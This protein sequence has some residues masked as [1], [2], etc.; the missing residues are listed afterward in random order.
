M[1]KGTSNGLLFS[2][3]F[4]DKKSIAL[5]AGPLI[6]AGII[7]LYHPDITRPEIGYTLAIALWMAVWWIFEPVS[8]AITSLLPVVLFP[9]LG[10]MNGQTVSSA[11][12]NHVIFLF[13]GGFLMALAMQRWN[14]HRRIALNILSVTGTSKS[15][16]L[17]GFM[18]ATAF[19]SMW[20]SNTATAMMIVPIL[21]SVLVVIEPEPGKKRSFS[22]GLLLGIA[23]SASIGGIITLVGTPPNLSFIRIYQ[24]MFPQAPAI[25]F[26][27]WMLFAVPI[28]I[29]LLVF[30]YFLLIQ[31]YSKGFENNIAITE[32]PVR[33]MR[34]ELGP[35]S[36]EE[37]AVMICFVLMAFL[38][39]TR[40]DIGLGT[41][42]LK[43]WAS[44]FNKPEF[45]NDGTIAIAI[46]LPLFMIPVKG[47]PGTRILDWETAS[48]LPWN[49]VLLFGGG[50][51][52]AN[53]FRDS[54]LSLWLGEKL[55]GISVLPPIVII[56]IICLLVT[57]LTELTSNTATI[58]MILPV[59]AGMAIAT[60]TNPLL[61]MVPATISGSMAFMLPAATPPN[62]I[63]FGTNRI[64]I[65]EMARTGFW[66]N[67]IGAVVITLVF[68]YLGS[69][70]F[71]I[72]PGSFP[73][74]AVPP[75]K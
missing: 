17:M 58:E 15:R 20:M 75:V 23:Y 25:S 10:V 49:I 18:L 64:T 4:T 14:L 16:L 5:L 47:Q 35:M 39:I 43:G 70:I 19:L 62:A 29:L 61:F 54:G 22:T 37:K 44:L 60:H 71:N 2:S 51:A 12:F 32:L 52:L 42:T 45:I 46:S 41:F 63:I 65:A 74:W 59:L 30:A 6:A 24:V 53:G 67:L 27:Q 1:K 57:F 68:Y 33:Q 66:L 9:V 72:D 48:Q 73:A 21:L 26:L 13:I 3:R 11:Y 8:L 69:A 56:L 38:W 28:G 7:I 55:Q 40:S 31:R 50:F 34:R 36:R